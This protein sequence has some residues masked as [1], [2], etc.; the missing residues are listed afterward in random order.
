MTRLPA[1][2]EA[3]A[4]RAYFSRHVLPRAVEAAARRHFSG[5]VAAEIRARGHGMGRM[6]RAFVSGDN[7]VVGVTR[8]MDDAMSEPAIRAYVAGVAGRHV[9][10]SASVRIREIGTRE[11][12]VFD[13]LGAY[14]RTYLA[15]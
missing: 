12:H 7:V 1:E 3:R 6:W 2:V 13:A 14:D 10:K 9:L 8:A 4:W 11:V 5:A 15:D